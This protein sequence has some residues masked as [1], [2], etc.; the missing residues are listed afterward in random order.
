MDLF[1][2]ASNL[3]F[4]AVGSAVGARL[5]ARA[6]RLRTFPEAALGTGLLSFAG[7]AQ[8]CTI[9]GSLAGA[10]HP[11][12]KAAFAIATAAFSALAVIAVFAFTWQVFRRNERWAIALAGAGAAVAIA[13]GIGLVHLAFVRLDPATASAPSGTWVALMTAGFALAF[14]WTGV[15]S[16]AYWRRVRR[17]AR[18]GL[19]DAVV[20]NRFLLW[21][22]GCAIGFAI[23]LALAALALGGASFSANA[24]P[25]LL[26]SV[27]GLVNAAVWLLSFTPPAAYARWIERR[28]A[29]R[30]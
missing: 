27:T 18:V 28:A 13:A 17:R 23:E 24:L 3:L 26:I 4:I 2:V 7:I 21:G 19:G 20:A 25:R 8:P 5:L 1:V 22:A 30:S 16:L 12:V 15:E 14:G 29:A 9:A 10:G 6:L 11:E